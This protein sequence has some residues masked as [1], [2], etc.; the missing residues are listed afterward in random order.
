MLEK[1]KDPVF[2]SA[3]SRPHE[4]GD[5]I[6]KS[7]QNQVREYV[8]EQRKNKAKAFERISKQRFGI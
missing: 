4:N 2:L 1:K 5:K 8:E 6:G 7:S 3:R